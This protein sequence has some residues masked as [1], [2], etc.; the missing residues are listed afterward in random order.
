MEQEIINAQNVCHLI[1]STHGLRN[2]KFNKKE[3]IAFAYKYW[4]TN[5]EDITELYNQ[6]AANYSEEASKLAN[7]IGRF[8]DHQKI[9]SITRFT[10]SFFDQK[11][12]VI[13]KATEK[14]RTN[15]NWLSLYDTEREFSTQSQTQNPIRYSCITKDGNIFKL[16]KDKTNNILG[17]LIDENIP[18]AKCIVT[19]SFIYYAND[20]MDEY[21]NVLK[22]IK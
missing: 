17:I 1:E 9:T 14:I 6:L 19:G 5:P 3:K 2:Q 12:E 13:E 11:I 21:I 16:D 20:N 18:T 10:P 22:K 4:K 7:T 8:I 15:G